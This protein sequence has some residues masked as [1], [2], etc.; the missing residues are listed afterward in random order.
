MTGNLLDV[1]FLVALVW[2]NHI[3]HMSARNWL[4]E[5]REEPFVTCTLTENSL[6][7]LSM[8][9]V[10]VGEVVDF[11]S[12]CSV[13]RQ[14][15]EHPGHRFWSMDEDFLTLVRDMHVSGYRQV[16]DACLLGLAAARNGRLVTLDT[17]MAELLRQ[18]PGLEGHLVIVES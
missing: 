13:L 3:Q 1:N 11:S 2:E 8:N 10:V 15:K 5:H 4:A 12:A 17:R 16:T 6:I 14:L 18:A 7:R 9:P